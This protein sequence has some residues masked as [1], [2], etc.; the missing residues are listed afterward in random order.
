MLQAIQDIGFQ[1]LGVAVAVMAKDP[2]S[3]EELKR[4]RSVMQRKI[5]AL[6][7]VQRCKEEDYRNL[8]E[9]CTSLRRDLRSA[10]EYQEDLQKTIMTLTNEL[11]KMRL[12]AANSM[13]ISFLEEPMGE[14]EN[15]EEPCVKEKSGP[16]NE[17]LKIEDKD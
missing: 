14:E 6:A 7:A 2:E 15:I 12:Q 4:M 3:V 10:K 5:T 13:D 17:K 11:E 8:H 16:Y 1:M 9:K